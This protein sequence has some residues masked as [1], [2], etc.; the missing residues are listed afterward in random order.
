M[1][2]NASSVIVNRGTLS[3]G[4]NDD[5]VAGVQ[6]LTGAISGTTGTLTSSS[7][8]DLRSGTVSAIL[9]GAVGLNKTTSGTVT[10]S[11][12]NTYSGTT[13]VSAGN[14]TLS[15]GSAIADSGVVILNGGTLQVD[16]A[17]T[18]G[19]LSGSGGTAVTLNAGLTFGDAT[20]THDREHDRR[21][22]RPH[23]AGHEYR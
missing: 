6:L 8:Y 12:G 18:I 11:G 23:Q 3:I 14:L 2:P 16:S 9:G 7:D 19:R 1:L 20:G 22:R 4:A 21:R 10:L 15:G 13:T 17:E 5:T